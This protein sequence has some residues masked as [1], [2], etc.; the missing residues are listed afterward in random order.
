MERSRRR[1]ASWA[2]ALLGIIAAL[3]CN[4]ILARA[5]TMPFVPGNCAPRLMA[6]PKF[7]ALDAAFKSQ[8][9]G[10]RIDA[11]AAEYLP[12]VPAPLEKGNRQVAQNLRECSAAHRSITTFCSV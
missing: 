10:G 4:A 12:A 11:H 6:A 5:T 8:A 9:V 3:A 1:A 7:G 2:G